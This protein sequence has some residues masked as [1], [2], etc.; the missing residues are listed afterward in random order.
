MAQI[1]W[2]ALVVTDAAGTGERGHVDG[3]GAC[4]H[5]R[6]RGGACSGAGREDVIHEQDVPALHRRWIGNLECTANVLAALA[7]REASLAL[8][9]AQAHERS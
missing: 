1:E 7:R 5:E 9:G 4:P 6:L 8:G 3:S 2:N